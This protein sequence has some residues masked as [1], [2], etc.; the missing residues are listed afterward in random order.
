M[1]AREQLISSI[2]LLPEHAVQAINTIVQEIV[3]TNEKKGTAD[4]PYKRGCM[5][6]KMWMSEDFDEPL[7]DF[8]EYM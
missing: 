2:N 1:S 4:L 8:E 6:G 3:M 5:K 7:D